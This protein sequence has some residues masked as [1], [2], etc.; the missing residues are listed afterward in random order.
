M[1]RIWIAF[2][3]VNL[4]LSACAPSS[5]LMPTQPAPFTS[6]STATEVPP[7]APTTTPGG[8]AVAALAG[9]LAAALAQMVTGLTVGKKKYAEAEAEMQRVPTQA[10]ALRRELLDAVAEDSAAFEAVMAAYRL[11]QGTEEEKARHEAT[12]QRALAEAATVP[13]RVA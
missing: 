7:T 6:A 2:L 10:Q 4:I 3:L 11:P 9:A 13:L 12:L 5:R 8:G 1:K